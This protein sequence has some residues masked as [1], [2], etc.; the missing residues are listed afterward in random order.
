MRERDE[1]AKKNRFRRSVLISAKL[2]TVCWQQHCDLFQALSLLQSN[3][4][5]VS[6]CACVNVSCVLL[7][8]DI[9]H[10]DVVV[11]ADAV[12]AV[13]IVIVVAV[14]SSFAALCCLVYYTHR[15]VRVLYVRT[16]LENFIKK[17]WLW[18]V[19]CAIEPMRRHN[20]QTN[21]QSNTHVDE[22]QNRMPISFHFHS[23][24]STFLFLLL[25]LILFEHVC[26]C[27]TL[28]A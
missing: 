10:V 20:E 15:A 6:V 13:V 24:I 2:Q 7:Y 21:K 5:R 16:T 12:A 11:A 27:D 23:F 17:Y 14:Y 26:V 4:M 9:I 28:Y 22:K 1:Q 8:I 25:F 19:M 18:H 3:C